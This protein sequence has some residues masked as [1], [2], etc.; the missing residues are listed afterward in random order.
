MM[1]WSVARPFAADEDDRGRRAAAGHPRSSACTP[2]RPTAATPRGRSPTPRGGSPTAGA[3]CSSPRAT[4]RRR[5]PSRCSAARASRR[6]WTPTW[7]GSTPSVV[8]VDLRLLD[9]GFVDPALRLAVLTETDL[10]GQKAATKDAGPDAGPAP[11][12]H[13]P[14]DAAGRRLHRARAARRGPLHRDGAAHRAGRHPRVPGRRVRARQAR[15]ARRPALRPHRPAG[16]G[17][18]VR[19]RRGAHP[20][21][22][23]RRRLDEDQGARQEGGQGDR[24]RPD[25]ALLRADGRPRARLRPRTPP[26]SGSWRTPSRTPRRPTSSPPSTRSRRTWR[27]RSRWTG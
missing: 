27:S 6:A 3:R 25:P 8:H 19:R 21:P 26:G 10:S 24:R 12:D 22:A 16:A 1:W 7:P 13:R 14:A 11:Q 18:P 4:A 2:R 23:R 9:N 20:A 5:V 17:H 15:P